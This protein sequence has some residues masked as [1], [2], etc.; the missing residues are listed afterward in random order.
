[1]YKWVTLGGAYLAHSFRR[2]SYKYSMDLHNKWHWPWAHLNIKPLLGLEPYEKQNKSFDSAITLNL[3][4]ILMDTSKHMNFSLM[5]KS[6]CNTLT[7]T[8]VGLHIK[9]M[10]KR[11]FR[12]ILDSQHIF[13]SQ[14]TNHNN[15]SP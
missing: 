7:D 13:D 6:M 15:I 12:R 9:Y 8:V 11:M 3:V 5:K 4:D 10:F 2:H 14:H 1:M